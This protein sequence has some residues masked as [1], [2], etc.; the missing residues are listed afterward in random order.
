MMTVTQKSIL[1][2]GATPRRMAYYEWGDISNP[3]TVLCVH[4]LTRNGRDFDFLARAL[5]GNFRVIAPDLAGRGKSDRLLNP[6]DYHPG[7]YLSDILQLLTHLRIAR[8]HWV[9]TSL[10]GIVGMTA[11]AMYP[12]IIHSLVLNDI[13]SIIAKEGLARIARYATHPPAFKTADEAEHYLRGIFAPFGIRTQDQ[14][15][16]LFEHSLDRLPSGEF[17][18]AYD[19]RIVEP[20]RIQTQDYSMITDVDLSGLWQPIMCPVLLY[21]GS[22]SDILRKD[23]AH[24]MA[25]KPEVTLIEWEGIGH[26]PSLMDDAHITG[27]RHFLGQDS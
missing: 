10:G 27:I 18:P 4:G 22:Q 9:G 26:A 25:E 16:H 14:W 7:T 23:T 3:D 8:V 19:P 5:E 17:F 12:L 2:A 24:T 11:A 1:L 15:N 20:M 6:M 13:G 21:R